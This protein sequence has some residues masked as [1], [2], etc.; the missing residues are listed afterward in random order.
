MNMMRKNENRFYRLEFKN[1]MT[2]SD[3]R[4]TEGYRTVILKKDD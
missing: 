4:K 2:V 3:V 1:N